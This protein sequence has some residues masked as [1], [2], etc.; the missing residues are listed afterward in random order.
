MLHCTVTRPRAYDVIFIALDLCNDNDIIM[1]SCKAQQQLSASTKPQLLSLSRF[2]EMN[3]LQAYKV[4]LVFFPHTQ[5]IA[6][7]EVV[8]GWRGLGVGEGHGLPQQ[9]GDGWEMAG[10]EDTVL[11]TRDS[12]EQFSKLSPCTQHLQFTMQ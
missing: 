2:D 1:R 8:V 10:K 5:R 7:T 11:S 4:W 12:S 3:K 6:E 9:E